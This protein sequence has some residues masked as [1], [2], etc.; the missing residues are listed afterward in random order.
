[1]P[2]LEYRHTKMPLT[3][4]LMLASSSWRHIAHRAGWPLMPLV[5]LLPRDGALMAENVRLL[6]WARWAT[7]RWYEMNAS[8]AIVR[9]PDDAR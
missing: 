9:M 1:M 8:P 7:I 4:T 5:R 3:P 2:V 6:A